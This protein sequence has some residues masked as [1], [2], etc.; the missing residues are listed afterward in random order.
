M[1]RE[2]IEAAFTAALPASAG[3]GCVSAERDGGR[4]VL[5]EIKPDIVAETRMD[6]DDPRVTP[7]TLR[8]AARNMLRGLAEFMR[9]ASDELIEHLRNTALDEDEAA[10]AVREVCVLPH[11][12]SHD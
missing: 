4:G 6:A 3:L 9:E 1:T 7:E 11:R 8:S 12:C 10:D 2:E 5:I